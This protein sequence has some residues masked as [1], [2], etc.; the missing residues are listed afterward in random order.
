[1]TTSKAQGSSTRGAD[2]QGQSRRSDEG[3]PGTNGFPSHTDGGGGGGRDPR[4]GG[5]GGRAAP[6]R[7]RT[8]VIG[9]LVILY[10]NA[11]SILSKLDELACTAAEL[12]PDLILITESWYKDDTSDALLQISGYDLQMRRD[13]ADMV[14]GVGGGLLVYGKKGLQFVPLDNVMEF[15]QHCSFKIRHGKEESKFTLVYRLP[16]NAT[17][18]LA[19][20]EEF[21]KTVEKRTI[22]IGDFNLPMI[23]WQ[24]GR[25]VGTAASQVLE[26]CNDKFLEQLVTFP[27]HDRGN[28]LDL[29]LTNIPD[30]IEEVENAGKLGSSDHTMLLVTLVGGGRPRGGGE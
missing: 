25:A 14:A 19:D 29:V 3:A 27:T 23:D 4:G 15:N 26:A 11:Q 21:I 9:A 8:A 24:E 5:G 7:A 12:K 2:G 20:L 22:L 30:E 6:G 17:A 28:I 16:R 1:V 10:L 13:R 18:N